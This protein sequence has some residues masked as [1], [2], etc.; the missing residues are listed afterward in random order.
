[1]ESGTLGS[2][3][4][5]AWAMSEENVE[6]VRKLFDAFNRGDLDALLGFLS[7]EVAWESLPLPG[8]R[9]VYRGRAEAREWIELLLEI[10]EEGHLGIDDITALSDDRVFTGYTQVG[11]GRGSG[12][13]AEQP[14]WAIFWLADGLITRRQ[15]F[16][17]RDE[18]LE[19]AGLRE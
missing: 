14:G 4:D 2:S 11:R 7:P 8:F 19:A 13:P 1:M 10:F 17:S 15:V 3:R 9:D 5:T 12:L 16:W 6:V 18:A